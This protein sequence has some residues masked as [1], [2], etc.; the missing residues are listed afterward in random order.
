MKRAIIITILATSICSVF[1]FGMTRTCS[2]ANTQDS[3]EALSEPITLGQQIVRLTPTKKYGDKYIIDG[4]MI[5]A[6]M[7]SQYYIIEHNY[8][9]QGKTLKI[10]RGCVLEFRG[11]SISNGTLEADFASISAPAIQI[12]QT[13]VK[14]TGNWQNHS[15][16]V[17]WYGAIGDNK[18]N[19][20]AAIN[21]A[22]NNTS[23][24]VVSLIAGAKYRINH[25][26]KMR[27]SDLSFGC[28][29]VSYSHENSPAAYIYSDCSE[30]IL[31]F[32]KG[33]T[34]KGLCLK[35]I[36]L[37]KTGRYNYQGDGIHIQDASLYRSVFEGVRIYYCNNGFYQHFSDG[38]RGYSLNKM[39][40]CIFSGCLHG[41]TLTHDKGGLNSYWVNLNSWDNCHFGFNKYGGLTIHN[42]YSC[43]QNIFSSCGFEGVS[44][45]ALQNWNVD[46]DVYGARLNGQGYGLTTFENCYFE[47]NHP[48]KFNTKPTST[49]NQNSNYCISDVI[50]EGMLISFNHCTFNDGITP[51]IIRNGNI[52]VTIENTIF[53]NGYDSDHIVLFKGISTVNNN[54][55]NYLKIDLPYIEQKYSKNMVSTSKCS[56]DNIKKTFNFLS[57]R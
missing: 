1:A 29:E 14:L 18:T 3:S 40:N 12:F 35:G 38:Y 26:I 13:D 25:A 34:V 43:E 22:I 47:R 55:K 5:N 57:I 8:D 31:D 16:P 36:V 20:T 39:Q 54:E 15:L 2:D 56:I 27:S 44:W 19:S 23:F 30:N 48:Q 45:D 6:N 33:E 49:L 24:H 46:T 32:P 51:I 28:F 21:A 10:P 9:M 42:V 37:H 4:S 52:G 50:I 11:G 53:R 41:F 7:Q 17:E